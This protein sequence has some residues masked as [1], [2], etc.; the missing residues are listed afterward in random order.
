MPLFEQTYFSNQS[1][2]QTWGIYRRGRYKRQL[3]YRNQVQ[4]YNSA[5]SIFTLFLRCFLYP[6]HHMPNGFK[7]NKKLYF[8]QLCLVHFYSLSLS[9]SLFPL[10]WVHM[11][12][13]TMR[14]STQSLFI[15]VSFSLFSS[16]SFNPHPHKHTHTHIML[17][18]SP[19]PQFLPHILHSSV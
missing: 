13:R 7:G 5:K 14:T 16:V 17:S 6:P 15:S 19:L 12:T 3:F 4:R 8:L 1:C 18:L 11:H 2:N 10:A 9:L